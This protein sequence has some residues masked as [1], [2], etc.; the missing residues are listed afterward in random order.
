[1]V[2][3]ALS[4]NTQYTKRYQLYLFTYNGSYFACRQHYMEVLFSA[5]VLETRVTTDL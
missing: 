4:L 1:M 2:C 3:I 5:E